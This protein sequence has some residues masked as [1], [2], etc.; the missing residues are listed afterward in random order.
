MPRSL[1]ECLPRILF[2]WLCRWGCHGRMEG[3][4]KGDLAAW[5]DYNARTLA[6]YQAPCSQ[7]KRDIYFAP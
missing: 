2:F 4:T 5:Q 1:S 7:A 3:L 6:R